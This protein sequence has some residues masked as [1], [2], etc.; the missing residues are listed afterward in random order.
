[1]S[2]LGGYADEGEIEALIAE[3]EKLRVDND[4]LRSSLGDSRAQYWNL[5]AEVERAYNTAMAD[6]SVARPNKSA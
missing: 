6:N 4:T 1:M 2:V 5:Q 3:N